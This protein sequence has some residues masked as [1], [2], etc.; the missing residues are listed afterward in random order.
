M[1]KI[2]SDDVKENDIK[3]LCLNLLK[4]SGAPLNDNEEVKLSWFAVCFLH[5]EFTSPKPFG[6]QIFITT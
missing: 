6:V 5:T 4:S 3:S 1:Q 2:L